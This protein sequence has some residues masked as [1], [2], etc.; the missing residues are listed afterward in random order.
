MINISDILLVL[1]PESFVFFNGCLHD[2]KNVSKYFRWHLAVIIRKPERVISQDPNLCG[3]FR[4]SA[5]SNMKMDRFIIL[6]CPKIN[7]PS[8]ISDIYRH[9]TA[10]PIWS[11]DLK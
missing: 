9:Q 1:D 4:R 6:I 11:R 5:F 7:K 2:S 10:S 3:I 8:A